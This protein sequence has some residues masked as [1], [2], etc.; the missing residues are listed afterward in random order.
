MSKNKTKEKNENKLLKIIT[1]GDI[2][3]GNTCI[4]RRFVTG[5]F[6]KNTLSMI[7]RF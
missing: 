4:L 7:D 2:G 3:V 6:D 5:K 1:L